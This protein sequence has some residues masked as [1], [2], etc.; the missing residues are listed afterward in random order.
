M[1]III[2]WGCS[3]EPCS[4]EEVPGA[5]LSASPR[6][7]ER[8]RGRGRG[9]D[10]GRGGASRP[11][12]EMIASGPFALGP[13][14]AGSSSRRT[15][16][17]SNFTPVVPFGSS[18]SSLDAGLTQTEAPK[19]KDDPGVSISAEEIEV[20]SDQEDGVEI[21]DIQEIKRMDWMAPET[22][23][24]EVLKKTKIT[25]KEGVSNLKRKNKGNSN[26]YT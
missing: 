18:G 23:Q 1:S 9:T 15:I 12:T 26:E 13:S 22:L 10:G 17:R 6:G 2:L 19:L 11:A 16:P 4:Q 21:I 25:K 24:K 14:M 20:Y 3:S 7:Q 8:G 5:L